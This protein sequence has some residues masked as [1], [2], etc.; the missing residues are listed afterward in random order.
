MKNNKVLPVSTAIV[1][2]L[3]ILMLFWF[4]DQSELKQHK[5]LNRLKV[6]HELSIIR[7]KLENGL[8]S[9]LYLVSG[10]IAY[11]TLNPDIDI[12]SSRKEIRE[13]SRQTYLNM[14]YSFYD[15]IYPNARRNI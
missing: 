15:N 3:F 4:V 13:F 8:N 14:S 10:L 1:A 6:L 9:R 11:T 12:Y 5:T 7:D 2:S